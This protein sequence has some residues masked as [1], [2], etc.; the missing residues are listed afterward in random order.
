[1]A[2]H[3]EQSGQVLKVKS[4]QL[5]S[6][7]SMLN[8]IVSYAGPGQAM[9]GTIDTA[10]V[11]SQLFDNP[12]VAAADA[13]RRSALRKSILDGSA[14]DYQRLATRVSGDDRKRI[15]AHLDAVRDVEKRIFVQNGAACD[16]TSLQLPGTYTDIGQMRTLQ[17]DLQVLAF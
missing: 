7:D 17:L 13:A 6:C 14:A 5:G 11:F 8:E 10:S 1:I 4:L 12:T 15:Q 16:P 2:D 3:I 9:V